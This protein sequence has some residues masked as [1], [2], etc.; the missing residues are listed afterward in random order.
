MK[1]FKLSVALL[2]SGLMA[3]SPVTQASMSLQDKK[4][5]NAHVREVT[6][7]TYG[8]LIRQYGPLLETTSQSQLDSWQEHFGN[9]KL[10]Q[11]QAQ[12]IKGKNGQ[13]NLKLV[14]NDM[15]QTLTVTIDPDNTDSFD[16]NG[17]K[18]ALYELLDIPAAIKKM[19]ET[20]K[21]LVGVVETLPTDRAPASQR[22][23]LVTVDRF[24]QMKPIERV[25]VLS[26]MN[27]A[28]IAAQNVLTTV[29]VK[30]TEAKKTSQFI[31]HPL[32]A[33]QLA[34]AEVK[35]DTTCVVAGNLS[36]YHYEKD[37]PKH[38]ACN[39]FTAETEFTNSLCKKDG[40]L[41]NAKG[42]LVACNPLIHGL[43]EDAPGVPFCVD[44]ANQ[45][46]FTN[47]ATQECN[48]M[49]P[50]DDP[51]LKTKAEKE[52]FRR[53]AYARILKTY[54]FGQIKGTKEKIEAC[55]MPDN[56]I[57]TERFCET[58]FRDHVDKF[59]KLIGQAQGVCADAKQKTKDQPLACDELLSRKLLVETAV[60][61]YGPIKTV[62]IGQQ[63]DSCKKSGGTY[64][65]EKPE[66]PGPVVC[67]CPDGSIAKQNG[68]EF[69][70]CPIT[71]PPPTKPTVPVIEKST[72]AKKEKKDNGL[73]S[74]G[75]MIGCLGLGMLAIFGIM[76][77]FKKDPKPTTPVVI[78]P[79]VMPPPV[80]PVI[81]K[82][83]GG[84]GTPGSPN[85]GGVRQQG[86]H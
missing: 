83:E 22:A 40:K 61:G 39:P 9:R 77:W 12:M 81:P 38:L 25:E 3:Y 14:Y 35:E 45:P 24:A 46:D 60:I 27:E 58:M 41:A 19:A 80:V 5:F 82:T 17:T 13:E 23:P 53:K 76:K 62:D 59:N 15:G 42:P 7:L 69:A 31:L 6:K 1:R 73:C 63:N 51:N 72:W 36:T 65:P 44:S 2:S 11:V 54:A 33:S 8:D 56:R 20:N 28:A 21:K 70:S 78:P 18:F 49:S 86:T 32:I 4:D 84:T 55:F 64:G 10:P 75:W 52:A 43:R 71:Q 30:P 26:L 50:I 66:G 74:G 29:D 34:L 79:P 47:Y 48:R 68:N 85:N 16:I 57:K 37:R 67:K